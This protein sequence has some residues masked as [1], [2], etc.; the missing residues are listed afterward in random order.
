MKLSTSILSLAA[1]FLLAG[2]AISPTD[3]QQPRA[4]AD[5]S[6]FACGK[7]SK[8]GGDSAFFGPDCYWMAGCEHDPE[9]DLGHCRIT[10]PGLH[11]GLT[12]FIAG[13]GVPL[14]SVGFDR[15]TGHAPVVR[16]D[17]NRPVTA[18]DSVR[19]EFNREQSRMLLDQ[20]LAGDTV[21]TSFK[22]RPNARSKKTRSNLVG[23]TRAYQFAL[24]WLR[25]R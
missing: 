2:C 16:V 11:Y 9:R 25:G 23:F 1:T 7:W 24:K 12:L 4:E 3:Q 8:R 19:G 10:R 18:A 14:A 15:H 17:R 13:G 21:T 22:Q 5:R 6:Q 20:L